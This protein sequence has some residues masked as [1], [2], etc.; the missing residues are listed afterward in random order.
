MAKNASKVK[1][2]LD[3]YGEPVAL[4]RKRRV[5]RATLVL[6]V[7]AVN[8]FLILRAA[9]SCDPALS[10]QVLVSA[11]FQKDLSQSALHLPA[12]GD[13][14]SFSVRQNSADGVKVYKLYHTNGTDEKGHLQLRDIVYFEG[15][16]ELQ[17]SFRQNTR[18]YPRYNDNGNPYLSFLVRVVD[19]EGEE[20]YYG[21]ALTRTN[22]NDSQAT[23]HSSYVHLVTEERGGYLYSRVA[24]DRIRFQTDTEYVT[25]FVFETD[26]LDKTVFT[27]TLSSQT[28]IRTPVPLNSRN[29]LPI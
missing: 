15:A 9:Q 22:E 4:T 10:E 16:D 5:L 3:E 8:V 13:F 7:L 19:K 6:L 2:V 14:S 11:A 23:Y 26:S 1:I 29:F 27:A 20:H 17:F 28:G 21:S 25:L 24:F 18:F 12:P